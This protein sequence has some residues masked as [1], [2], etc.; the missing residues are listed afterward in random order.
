ML[1]QHLDE[2]AAHLLFKAVFD[3]LRHM[4]G[5]ISPSLCTRSLPNAGNTMARH[6][7]VGCVHR[8]LTCRPKPEA[9]LGTHTLMPTYDLGNATA[10][11]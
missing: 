5:T 2:A 8:M 7:L 6:G 9:H 3:C 4:Q 11:R 1:H 10:Y